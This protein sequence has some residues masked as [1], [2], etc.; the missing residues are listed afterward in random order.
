MMDTH[1]LGRNRGSTKKALNQI[2]ANTLAI[3]VSS[4]ILF[5]PEEL[6]F[7]AEHVPRSTYVEIDS[8]FGHD[9][10]LVESDQIAQV[11]RNFYQYQE[12]ETTA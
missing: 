5:P 7:I 12:N 6:K 11:V 4:D 10:F 9:G 8:P 3:G 1:N 2:R